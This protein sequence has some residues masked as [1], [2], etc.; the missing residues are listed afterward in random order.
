MLKKNLVFLIIGITLSITI[1]SL[2]FYFFFQ[3]KGQDNTNRDLFNQV[4]GQT[5]NTIDNEGEGSTKTNL[6]RQATDLSNSN[7]ENLI[8]EKTYSYN[9]EAISFSSGRI[10][11]PATGDKQSIRIY[12]AI[13]DGD[14]LPLVVLVSGGVNDGTEFEKDKGGAT[15]AVKLAAEGFVVIV[16]SALGLGESAGEMNFQ[17]FDDQD[18]LAAIVAA[19]KKLADV[20]TSKVGLASFSYGIT[21]TT[22]VLARYPD[23][24]IK[25][26]SDWEGPTSRSFTSPGCSVKSEEIERTSPG[27]FSCADNAHWAEREAVKFIP[28][29]H[30][31][32]Y[33]RIQQEE[34]HVQSTYNHTLEILQAAVGKIPWVKLND[35]EVN[36]QY[37]TESELN[38]V[39][40]EKDV[41]GIYVIPHLKE[42]AEM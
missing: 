41:F 24:D 8:Q 3:S 6:W 7:F 17:G 23:L 42:M 32:Y 28:E 2:A 1:G 37:K 27:S 29:A 38:I 4:V 15:N 36:Q 14:G 40:N 11:N 31:Q 30:V 25:F 39:P 9:N 34:D 26:Y 16:Y 22:G 33:W 18:G 10:T 5:N 35:G 13:N 12:S 21:G 20:D 19:G